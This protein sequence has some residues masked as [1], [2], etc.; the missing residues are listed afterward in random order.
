MYILSLYMADQEMIQEKIGEALGL[1]KAAQKAVEDLDSRGLLKPEHMKK[2][3]K[4]RE[5]TSEQEEEMQQLVK[6]L[7]DSDGLDPS[8]IEETAEE[9]AEKA[10]KIMETY[11][12]EDPDTQEALEFLC[13]AEGGEVTHYE[14][15]AAVAKD[16]KNKKFGTKVRAILQE[17]KRH[18]AL[19]TK[20]AK[21]NAASE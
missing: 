5:E 6:E 4:M 2:L 8:A 17:E 11:L 7:A 12:G 21:S 14:V 1:E 18:L 16:V 19:C 3:A 10:S 15:L 13:L 9:T 20:L